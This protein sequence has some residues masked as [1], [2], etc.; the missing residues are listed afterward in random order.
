MKLP[1]IK[2]SQKQGDAPLPAVV[3]IERGTG[4]IWVEREGVL[5]PIDGHVA[6]VPPGLSTATTEEKRIEYS[7]AR[8]VSDPGSYIGCECHRLFTGYGGI[9]RGSVLSYTDGA[10]WLKVEYS[11]DKTVEDYDVDDMENFVIRCVEGKSPAA[12]VSQSDI[13]TGESPTRTGLWE[14]H[15]ST[16]SGS[17]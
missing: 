9:Y 17:I 3:A 14:Q 16:Q 8:L 6:I 1:I 7:I 5:H 4:R 11:C 2:G 12:K 10:K 13:N 15:G